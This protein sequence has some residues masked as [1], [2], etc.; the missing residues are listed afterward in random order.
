MMD[1]QWILEMLPVGVWTA[2]VPTGEVAYANPEFQRIMGMNAVERSQIGDASATYGIFDLAGRPY[3]LE[4]LP[5]SRVVATGSPATVDDLVI[6]R[7]HGGKVNVRAFGYPVRDGGGALTHV[8][9]AFIDIT[10]ELQAIAGREQTESRAAFA[11]NHAPIVLW[12]ADA[13]GTVTL[14]EGA[15]L[16]SMGVKSGQLVGQNLFELY[17]DHPSIAGYLRR[18]LAG[19]SFSYTVQVGEAIYDSSLTPVRNSSGAVTGVTGLSRDITE[20]RKLQTN[21]IQNDRAIALGTLAASLA[22]EINNPLTYMLGHLEFV[23]Q[24][25]G[26]IERSFHE[27]PE[28]QRAEWAALAQELRRSLE[29]VQAGTRRIADITRE[30]RTFIRPNAEETVRADARSVVTSVLKL[31]GKELE[32]RA[33]LQV[34]LHETAPVRADASRLVQVVLNLLVNAMQ[35]LSGEGPATNRIWVSTGNEGDQ[36]VIEVS[37]NGPGV[38]PDK[39]ERIFEPFVTTKEV[40]QGS[41]LGLFVCRNIVQGFSGQVAVG[42]RSGGGAKFRVLL[43]AVGADGSPDVPPEAAAPDAKVSAIS[44][45]LIIDD[46]PIV[47]TT[48]SRQLEAAGYRVQVE[49][50][51]ARAIE[52]L[53]SNVDGIGLVFCDLMMRG[54]SGM[55]LR[56]TLAAR[57]PSQLAKV[58]FMTGGAFT[59][60]ARAFRERYA[61]QCVDKPFD[62][63]GEAARRLRAF[64]AT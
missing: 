29:P 59:P 28:A 24:S 26:R 57:A 8:I 61:D 60:R 51:A 42:D 54:I 4:S 18:G 15:G 43:P 39:R 62:V 50:D 52:T 13:K 34:D 44:S 6:H 3:P 16:A 25:L 1:L 41:G 64:G 21:A 63:V 45:V 22:H 53:T 19:E 49:A 17:R 58:V 14:S 10:R 12:C 31:V 32:A 7:P 23:D 33:V 47:T 48:L 37:D 55:D 11:I 36:V 38:P 56:E 30:L 20:I 40:G 5:F 35:A 9:V 27:L 46:D 2:K